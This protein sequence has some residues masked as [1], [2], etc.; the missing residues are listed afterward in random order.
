L[1]SLLSEA[2][3]TGVIDKGGNVNLA[4]RS[5]GPRRRARRSMSLPGDQS[6]NRAKISSSPESTSIT[7]CA[8]RL[9]STPA[10]PCWRRTSGSRWRLRTR[11]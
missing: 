6:P 3:I 1:I 11:S 4:A 10:S 8:P 9:P 7:C 2:F 5:S